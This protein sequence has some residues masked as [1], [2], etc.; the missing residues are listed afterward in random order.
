MATAA[1]YRELAEE[2]F[3]W[4]QEARD[5]SVRQHYAK[6]CEIWLESAARAEYRSDIIAR[7]DP[8]IVEK[9]A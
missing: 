4:A 8:K 7:S 6:L 2:C 9:A 5:V 3:Q 1:H